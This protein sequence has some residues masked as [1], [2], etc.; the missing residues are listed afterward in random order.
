MKYVGSESW[1]CLSC[2]QF[3]WPTWHVSPLVKKY[4][5]QNGCSHHNDNFMMQGNRGSLQQIKMV[6]DRLFRSQA[7]LVN[8]TYYALI[9]IG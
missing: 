7:D 2:D 3:K 9:V 1:S 5:Q 8:I 4:L 6:P